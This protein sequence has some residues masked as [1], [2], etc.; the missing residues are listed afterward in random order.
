MPG[1]LT[2]KHVLIAAAS[3]VIIGLIVTA[4]LV[5]IHLLVESNK[6]T[7][8]VSLFLPNAVNQLLYNQYKTSCIDAV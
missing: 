7:L 2:K 6:D 1:R 8:Q 5:G 4:F 3:V